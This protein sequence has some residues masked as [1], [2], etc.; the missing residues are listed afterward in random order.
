MSKFDTVTFQ[1]QVFN[2]SKLVKPLIPL[3]Q[4]ISKN[5]DGHV[6]YYSSSHE[7]AASASDEAIS[8]DEDANTVLTLISVG[9]SS[10]TNVTIKTN[11][12]S[13]AM[14]VKSERIISGALSA[15]TV[16]NADA[17]NTKDLLIGR[18]VISDTTNTTLKE[19]R[20]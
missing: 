7:I 14:S 6:R 10:D 20:E 16:S 2:D 8:L 13:T 17:T 1:E 5:N 11:G 18:I 15:I 19:I 3:L 9:D 4:W 12:D